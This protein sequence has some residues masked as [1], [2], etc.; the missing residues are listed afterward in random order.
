MKKLFTN[1][2]VR[3][4]G[5]AENIRSSRTHHW[6]AYIN[7]EGEMIPLIDVQTAGMCLLGIN[8][9]YGTLTTK[10]PNGLFAWHDYFGDVEIG[11]NDVATIHLKD[12]ASH[13]A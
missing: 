13:T 7:K 4:A 2:W 1:V 11:D 8:P 3:V 5:N 6:R 12:P 9:L 10:D